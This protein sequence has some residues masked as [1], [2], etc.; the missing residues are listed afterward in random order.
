MHAILATVGTVGDVFAQVGLGIKP[1]A[2]GH[3][4]TLTAPESFHALAAGRRLGA[5]R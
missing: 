3:D 2:R 5:A 4:V 1:R